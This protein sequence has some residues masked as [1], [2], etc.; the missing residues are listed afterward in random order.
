VSR[1]L[2]RALGGAGRVL[3]PL[4]GVVT[5]LGL[6]ELAVVAFD[7]KAFALPRPSRI[8]SDMVANP[9][10]FLRNGWATA[11]EAAIGLTV[12]AVAGAVIAVPMA[13]LRVVDRAV[14]PVATLVQVTPII[15][16]APAIVLWLGPGLGPIVVITALVCFVPFLFGAASGLRS[17]DPD[18][19]ELLRSVDARWWEVLWRL[20]VPHA[21]PYLFAAARTAVGLSLIGAALGEWFALVD[22]GLGWAIKQGIN[23]NAAPQVWGATFTMGALGLAGLGLV[24]LAERVSGLG[25][26]EPDR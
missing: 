5:F 2:G 17:V 14:A 25:R 1:A 22:E 12:G 3:A 13:H 16:Y 9:G 11:R 6:W 21:V 26:P 7:I 15:G 20:R 8:V 24:G 10:F 23:F 18:T 19:L 4:A